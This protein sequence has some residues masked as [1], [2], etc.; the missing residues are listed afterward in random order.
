MNHPLP[1]LIL[2]CG[3][4]LVAPIFLGPGLFQK[5]PFDDELLAQVRARK[6]EYVFIG[7]SML[8]TRLDPARFGELEHD[9]PV[10]VLA[11]HG[12][13]SAGW[14]LML[15]NF[16]VAADHQP[17]MVFIFFRDYALSWPYFRTTGTYREKMEPYM[18]DHEPVLDLV[19]SQ[20]AQTT[21]SR[22][23]SALERIY[24]IQRRRTEA[25]DVLRN[26]ALTLAPK[27]WKRQERLL[28]EV[29]DVFE[30]DN[31]RKDVPVEL[32]DTDSPEPDRF[33]SSPTASFVPHIIDLAK[34]NNLRVC[35]YRVKRRPPGRALRRDDPPDL[36]HYLR[37]LED[38][39]E[40]RGMVFF[41]ASDDVR[42]H[43]GMYADGDHIAEEYRTQWTDIFHDQV[44]PLLK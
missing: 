4:I 27:P 31:L 42:E 25:Q 30:L 13:S 10:Q 36:V 16:V 38:Y 29:N 8:L 34:K 37:T 14:F 39:V 1:R 11:G 20:A 44:Q 41:D 7:D 6:P 21:R 43:V 3:F 5:V 18:R 40:S 19:W 26:T 28:E 9:A 23:H 17:R 22:I 24:P 35:F 2:F 15:Q 33:D 12:L 32:S